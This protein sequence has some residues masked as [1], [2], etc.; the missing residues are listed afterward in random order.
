MKKLHVT[1]VDE[2][3]EVEIEEGQEVGDK[4]DPHFV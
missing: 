1:K 2:A 3:G 4:N